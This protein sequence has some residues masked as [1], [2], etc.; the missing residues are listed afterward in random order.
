MARE[1]ID[2]MIAEKLRLAKAAQLSGDA[3][4]NE[5]I[6]KAPFDMTPVYLP[7]SQ[8]RQSRIVSKIERYR[9]NDQ[10]LDLK[11]AVDQVTDFAGGRL[12]VHY[13]GDVA[14]LFNFI[15]EVIS[16]RTDIDLNGECDNYIHSPRDSGFRA[17][18]QPTLIQIQPDIWFPF[19]IQIMTYLAHDWDQKQHVIYENADEAPESVQATLRALA[20]RLLEADEKFDIARFLVKGFISSEKNE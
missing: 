10:T 19:E 20:Y 12:L 2:S 7:R 4:I 16:E 17:L 3:F 5:I 15:C 18:M 14:P 13:I 9:Q 8:K 1:Q 6:V 11:G